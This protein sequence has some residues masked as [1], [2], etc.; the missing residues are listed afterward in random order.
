MITEPVPVLPQDTP[1]PRR[2]AKSARPLSRPGQKGSRRPT[3]RQQA[4][5]LRRCPDGW[6]YASA[7]VV[8]RHANPEREGLS[9]GGDGIASGT[10]AEDVDVAVKISP[11]WR[12]VRADTP[13]R[14][15]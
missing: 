1:K 7:T 14:C 13:G 4:R 2:S 10:F 8:S 3:H 5:R 15:R 6:G 9:T 12:H 11:G